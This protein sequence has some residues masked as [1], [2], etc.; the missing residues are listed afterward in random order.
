[1]QQIRIVKKQIGG[2]DTRPVYRDMF[3]VICKE[4][5]TTYN[6]EIKMEIECPICSAKFSK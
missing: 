2:T 3:E 6:S 4:C 5:N 1:M